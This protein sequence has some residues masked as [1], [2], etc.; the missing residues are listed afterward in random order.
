MKRVV[1]TI[2][3]AC[4]LVIAISACEDSLA[5]DSELYEKGIDNEEVKK[6]DI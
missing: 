5:E 2:L 6:D 3:T 4:A 1:F